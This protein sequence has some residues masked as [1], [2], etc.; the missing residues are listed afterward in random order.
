MTLFV[1]T[2]RFAAEPFFFSYFKQNDFKSIYSKVNKYF[3]IIGL[4]IV[5]FILLNLDLWKYF[6][7]STYWEG[8][9]IVPVLLVANLFLGLYFNFSFWYKIINKTSIGAIIT[10]IGA[11]ITIIVNLA[12]VPKIGYYGSAIGR[13]ACYLSMTIIVIIWG[14]KVY[15]IKI[16][17]KNIIFYT[18]IAFILY[19]FHLYFKFNSLILSL[20]FNNLLLLSFVAFTYIVEKNILKKYES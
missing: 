20:I 5:L 2:F 13:L 12:L 7:C 19:L 4:I 8:L 17:F 9:Y 3:T 14:Q 6:I 16:E 11:I 1:Q 18:I 10:G 15:Q